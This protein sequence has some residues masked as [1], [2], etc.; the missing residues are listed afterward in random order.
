MRKLVE[1]Y[2]PQNPCP[3]PMKVHEIEWKTEEMLENHKIQWKSSE[4]KEPMSEIM[5]IIENVSK[6]MSYP[7][8]PQS[9]RSQSGIAQI[10][11]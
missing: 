2:H 10:F 9:T 8:N 3:K 4:D 11:L 1:P 5:K 6:S 7:E